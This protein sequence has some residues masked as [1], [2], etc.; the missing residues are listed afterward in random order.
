MPDTRDIESHAGFQA[1]GTGER[2]WQ[3]MIKKKGTT[4]VVPFNDSLATDYF[5]PPAAS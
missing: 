2:E 4:H 3:S 1:A 5:F